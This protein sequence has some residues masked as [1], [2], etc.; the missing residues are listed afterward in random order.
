MVNKLTNEKIAMH[1]VKNT[2][3]QVKVKVSLNMARGINNALT[4]GDI[5]SI[6]LGQ[7]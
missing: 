1:A 6:D 7:P 2:T 3:N 4:S 5:D